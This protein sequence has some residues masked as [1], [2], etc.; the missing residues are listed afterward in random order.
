[1]CDTCGCGSDEVQVYEPG[2]KS[3]SHAHGREH[4]HGLLSPAPKGTGRIINLE[5]NLLSAN[6]RKAAEN[7]NWFRKHNILPLNLVS[8][9]GSGKTSILERT[10]KNRKPG[11]NFYIIEGDQQTDN[12]AAR[13]KATGVPVVQVNTGTGC[14]LDAEMISSAVET[15]NPV[16]PGILFIENVGNLVCPALFDLGEKHKVVIISTAEG[17]D[18]PLKYPHMFKASSLCLINKIDLLPYLDFNIDQCISNARAVNPG[19]KFIEMSAKTGQGF[20]FWESW[21]IKETE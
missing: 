18:K 11:R 15:L 17:E 6:D 19:I 10:L 7:R 5:Q 20:E 21:F 3:H 12:D 4:D 1:M 9:P 2:K 13:I 16:G 8:S 14:H